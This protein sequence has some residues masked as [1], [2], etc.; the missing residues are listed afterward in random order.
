MSINERLAKTTGVGAEDAGTAQPTKVGTAAVIDAGTLLNERYRLDEM[1][2]HG[3]MGVVYRAHD[4]LLHRDVA[5][6]ILDK[7]ELGTEGRARLLR[8]AQATAQLN[9]PNIVAV[10]DAGET[11]LFPPDLSDPPDLLAPPLRGELKRGTAFIVM[12]LVEGESLHD[13][14][15]QTL[16]AMYVIMQQVCSALEHAHRHGVIHRDLKPENVLITPEGT[17]KLVDFGLARAVALATMGASRLTTEGD[18]IGT[19]FYLAPEQAMGHKIDHRVDLYALGIMLYEL[20]TGQLPFTGE[21]MLA[22]I[23]QHLH[24]PVVS[25][26]SLN[27]EIPPALDAMIVQLLSKQPEDRPASAA[28]VRK[29]LEALTSATTDGAAV[30][31]RGNLRS[32]SQA[33]AH[34][35]PAQTTPF[36][37]REAQLT[38]VKKALSRPDVRLLTLTG[39]GGTG[40]TRLGLQVATELL[41]DFPDGVY[42]VPLAPVGDPTFVIPAI[43]QTLDIR[44]VSGQPLVDRLKNDLRHKHMLL[45]LDNFEHVLPAAPVI[46][47]LLVS[48]PRLNVLVTSRALLRV[49]GEHGYNVPPLVL[50]D[51]GTQLPVENLAE[52]EAVQLFVDRASAVKAGFTLT[53][54]NASSV[55]EICTRLDGLPL[56]IELAAARVRLFTPPKIL[57]QL[58]DRLRLLTGGPRDLPTRHRSLRGAMDWSYNLLSAEAQAMFRRLSVFVDGCTLESAE[59]VNTALGENSYNGLCDVHFDIMQTME[60]LV[61]QSLLRLDDTQ[62]E[63]RFG[64]LETIREYAWERLGEHEGHEALQRAH[65]AYFAQF[66]EEAEGKLNGMEPVALEVQLA[67]LDRLEVEHGNLRAALGWALACDNPD[68]AALGLRLAV[69]LSPFW[70]TRGH[71]TEGRRWFEMALPKRYDAPKTLQAKVLWLAGGWQEN[72]DRARTFFEESLTLYQELDDQQGIARV[73]HNMANG[74]PTTEA[75]IE[76]LNQSLA[77]FEAISDK[78]GISGVLSSLGGLAWRQGQYERAIALCERSLEL[79]R[80]MENTRAMASLL[81]L[82][83]NIK[84]EQK[85]YERAA[86]FFEESLGLAQALGDKPGIASLLNSLGEM[87]RLQGDYERAA[88][89]YDESLELRRELGN[90]LL[91]AIMLHNLGY[92]ALRQGNKRHAAKFFEDSLVLHQEIDK[93]EA[94]GECLVGLA[95][96][97][98]AEDR[99]R[100]AVQL[101]GAAKAHLVSIGVNLIAADKAEYDRTLAEAKAALDVQT[102]DNAW[103]TGQAM[104]SAEAVIYAL[105]ER[106][107]SI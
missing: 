41:A 72:R 53:S 45:V 27:A 15:P 39:P 91:I 71:W 31:T 25:P 90:K 46:S 68:N 36:I 18:I 73:L 1:L 19:V 7:A 106:E 63:P 10:Y 102:F 93:K 105:A 99:P 48:A 5:V 9:H 11:E 95:G 12:E 43:A 42:F 86:G 65:G 35:L 61:D 8:E 21:E 13:R 79:A 44:E 83:G 87:A 85:E 37:G 22:V 4:V 82:L 50:P 56:A 30:A 92:V 40:K 20:A 75:S 103:A 23:S 77:L 67:W 49:Y 33:P 100:R 69:S 59:K 84:L 60:S 2:G 64:M 51:P 16:E 62:D 78:R 24:A 107:E 94:V 80:E 97:A 3:G 58:G 32:I 29:V 28:D 96:V 89:F 6:K 52:Y 104:T 98:V 26:Q 66:A 38:A 54:D 70:G 17:A 55:L 34:N 81:R 101:C 57:A 74:M 47:D 14:P 88:E 76:L